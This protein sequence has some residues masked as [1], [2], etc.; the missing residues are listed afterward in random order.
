LD[1][2]SGQR[3]TNLR[4]A[5]REKVVRIEVRLSPLWAHSCRAYNVQ[6]ELDPRT[7]ASLEKTQRASNA[8]S[9]PSWHVLGRHST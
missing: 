1:S 5:H 8:Q 7:K 6:I 2:P 3:A 4:E 9:Q